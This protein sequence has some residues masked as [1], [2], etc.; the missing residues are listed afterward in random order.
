MRPLVVLLTLLA[1]AGCDSQTEQ[2]ADPTVAPV[3][4]S[5]PEVAV[6]DYQAYLAERGRLLADLDALIG[7]AEADGPQSCWLLPVGE[8]ACGGP[9][10]YRVY[11]ASAPTAAEV[12]ALGRRIVALDRAAIAT[13]GIGST[14]DLTTAPEVSHRDGRCSA[15]VPDGDPVLT[16]AEL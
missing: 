7:D 12:L 9:T 14:C 8:K 2:I 3:Y 6:D 10:G 1:V 15:V 13:F 11:S 16:E 5:V 4:E